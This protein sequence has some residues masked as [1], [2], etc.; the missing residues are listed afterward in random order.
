MIVR[1]WG[2]ELNAT[3]DSN[4]LQMSLKDP[5]TLF[6]SQR[7]HGRLA[8]CTQVILYLYLVYI[9]DIKFNI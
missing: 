3:L 1:M 4:A 9:L 7:L 8:M 5:L 6:M 2:Q